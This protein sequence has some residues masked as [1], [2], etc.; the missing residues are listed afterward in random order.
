M[1]NIIETSETIEIQDLMPTGRRVLFAILAL[2]PLIA[3]YELIIRIN[4]QTY[5]HYFFL[6]ALIISLGAMALSAF[7]AF[8]AVAGLSSKLKIDRVRR[9]ISYA[10]GAPIVP[11]RTD[12]YP[13]K[14]LKELKNEKT[15]WSDSSP[16]Y[17]LV[18]YLNDEKTLRSASSFS[19]DEVE[20]I[21]Q[22]IQAFLRI[23]EEPLNV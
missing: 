11:W 8:A 16:S 20:A 7:L 2:F 13:L 23:G 4:W 5:F 18:V 14:A 12:E 15:D 6:L 9:T 22:K 17:T 19:S 10:S 3:P 21:L 1:I